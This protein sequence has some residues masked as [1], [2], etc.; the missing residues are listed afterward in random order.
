[1]KTVREVRERIRRRLENNLKS[2]LS[3]PESVVVRESLRVPTEKTA[4]GQIDQVIEWIGEWRS[5]A[6]RYS[7][8]SIEWVERIW[9]VRG[10]QTL[11]AAVVLTGL[12]SV[13][14]FVGVRQDL[15]LL[16]N[17]ALSLS[18]VAQSVGVSSSSAQPI[19]LQQRWALC[20][21]AITS[22]RTMQR[23]L[24]ASEWDRVLRV[25]EW[26]VTHPDSGMVVRALP[27]SGMDTKWLE[28]HRAVVSR[29]VEAV[30]ETQGLPG[31]RELG[32][33]PSEEATFL[34]IWGDPTTRPG[35]IRRAG[36]T[37]SELA[38]LDFCG[39]IVICENLATTV[40]MPDS[41]GMLYIHG[42]GYQVTALRA[43]PWIWRQPIVYWGDL[44][45]HG[46]EI[47]A[48][49]RRA[50]SGNPVEAVSRIRSALMD[51]E[52]LLAHRDLWVPEPSSTHKDIDQ[53][54][55]SEERATLA[56][57]HLGT[58]EFSGASIRLEQERIAWDWA[59]ERLDQLI[60]IHNS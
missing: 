58:D 41:P 53:W 35:G 33:A 1:M 28:K 48:R 44:D 25:V 47:L 40:A 32:L 23:S 55:T 57:L 13:A 45:S 34:V 18:A 59:I 56:F 9:R 38:S 49:L 43:I 42:G 14:R 8:V 21:A 37:L 20:V 16:R 10:A 29:C 46:F 27:I 52:T 4:A 31:G 15:E 22:T 30:R 24:T 2:W 26:V 7:D 39:T 12:D 3:D 50:L 6:D 17:R 36:L 19:D 5:I 54:L 11:P 51:T 60:P